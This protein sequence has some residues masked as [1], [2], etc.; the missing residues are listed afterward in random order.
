[1]DECIFYCFQISESKVTFI[2]LTN[3]KAVHNEVPDIFLEFCGCRFFLQS[4]NENAELIKR[5]SK[6]WIGREG[7]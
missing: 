6:F 3:A 5:K 2:E 7:K 1:M 4:V